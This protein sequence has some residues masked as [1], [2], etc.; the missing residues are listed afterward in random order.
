[1]S[2]SGVRPGAGGEGVKA[3]TGGTG[4]SGNSFD[5]GAPSGDFSS[6]GALLLDFDFADPTVAP[7]TSDHIL[8]CN[9]TVRAHT[10]RACI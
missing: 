3:G 9:S 6:F 8:Q 4:V 7:V 10:I 2:S 1:M 5:P